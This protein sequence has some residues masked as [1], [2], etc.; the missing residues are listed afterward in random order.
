MS[1]NWEPHQ[2]LQFADARLRPAVDLLLR[3]ELTNPKRVCD[4]G[5]GTG[6]VT[7]LLQRRWP[8]AQLTGIDN[9][10]TM[11]AEA[12]RTASEIEWVEHDL[13]T[14]QPAVP[15]DLIFSN[16]ALHWLPHEALLPRLLTF[17]SP[18]GCLAIQMP[19][20]FSAPSHTLIAETVRAGAWRSEL[21][22]LLRPTP[23]EA[24]QYYYQ[25]L[26]PRVE[27]VA[28]WEIEYLQ[29]LKGADPVK[30]WVKGT[31]LKPLLDRLDATQRTMFENDYALRLR[32]AYPATPSG[33]TLF[34]FKRLF[35]LARQR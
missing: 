1:V 14:W 25:L 12:A 3:V 10:A 11:L 22:D 18:G 2:Y 35:I 7:R 29:A 24:P 19:R 13:A 26:A 33:A 17:L 5:C 4:L 21:E 9:S 16:A 32:A 30:E 15:T 6:N 27:S 28:I 34:P 20:N 8:N 23:V 31:W